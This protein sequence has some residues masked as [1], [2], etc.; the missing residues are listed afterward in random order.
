[1]LA[2]SASDTSTLVAGQSAGTGQ[3]RLDRRVASRARCCP[4]ADL[5]V[6]PGARRPTM[7][8]AAR[9]A[10]RR[11]VPTCDRRQRTRRRD[12]V[13][14]RAVRARGRCAGAARA[15][16]LP[17]PPPTPAI[18]STSSRRSWPSWRRPPKWAS[19][20][21]APPVRPTRG[22]YGRQGRDAGDHASVKTVGHRQAC[23]EV[24]EPERT[25]GAGSSSRTSRHASMAVASR[26]SGSSAT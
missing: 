21:P 8:S 26:S 9:A 16:E 19:T 23:S 15:A 24:T 5:T 11:A 10:R 12:L 2:V 3:G 1:M 6:S 20:T 7:A 25:A 22:R 18:V 13:Q 14:P 17:R 4:I